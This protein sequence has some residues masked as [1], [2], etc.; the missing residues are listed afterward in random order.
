MFTIIEYRLNTAMTCAKRD[1]DRLGRWQSPSKGGSR[2]LQPFL[3]VKHLETRQTSLGF[4]YL[5]ISDKPAK[6]LRASSTETVKPLSK[7]ISRLVNSVFIVVGAIAIGFS[8][9]ISNVSSKKTPD[10]VDIEKQ[11]AEEIAAE[12]LF[13][14]LGS[15]E[16]KAFQQQYAQEELESNLAAAEQLKQEASGLRDTAAADATQTKLNAQ[17]SATAMR[18]EASYDG[19]G[20]PFHRPVGFVISLN[21]P[22]IV[23]KTETEFG[24][25]VIATPTTDKGTVRVYINLASAN[26]GFI[27]AGGEIGKVGQYPVGEGVK[28]F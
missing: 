6:V 13:E 8:L 28:A 14:Y 22:T 12:G 23:E 16:F 9:A 1:E 5:K 11:P 18:L 3:P 19:V 25:K 24:Y 2:S 20:P 27:P 15:P 17:Q 7:K 21:Y 10:P 26:E 4:P